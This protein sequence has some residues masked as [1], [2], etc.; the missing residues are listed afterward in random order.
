MRRSIYIYAEGSK[1]KFKKNRLFLLKNN[2]GLQKHLLF[3]RTRE[4]PWFI[5]T[6]VTSKMFSMSIHMFLFLRTLWRVALE[7]TRQKFHIFNTQ[8]RASFDEEFLLFFYLLT[9]SLSLSLSF[10]SF[11]TS[12][13]TYLTYVRVSERARAYVLI[14]FQWC[15]VRKTHRILMGCLTRRRPNDFRRNG[16]WV[17]RSFVKL[18]TKKKKYTIPFRLIMFWWSVT[19]YAKRN[20]Y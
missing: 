15:I 9:H 4:T 18:F 3:T 1:Q 10:S 12:A 2:H 6:I 7:L 17:K 20:M 14:F 19:L 8:E 11:Y 16:S 13:Y 5:D